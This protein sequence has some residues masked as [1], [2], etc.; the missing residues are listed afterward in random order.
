[1]TSEQ[2][3]QLLP[4]IKALS[5]GKTIQ[6]K[7]SSGWRDTKNFSFDAPPEY[8]RIKPEPK[9][10]PYTFEE[11]KEI[12]RYGP[13][14][15]ESKIGNVFTITGLIKENINHYYYLV[16]ANDIR[17]RGEFMLQDYK[18]FPSG[19]PCGIEE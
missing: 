19:N 15:V 1:M 4:I 18:L 11:W 7:Q 10:R 12:L 3:K 13:V 16:L 2:A 8:Y 9:L 6:F 5:E 14:Q 17:R